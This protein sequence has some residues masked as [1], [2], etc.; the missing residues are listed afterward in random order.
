MQL[1]IPSK[2]WAHG[3]PRGAHGRLFR[4]WGS[5]GISTTASSRLPAQRILLFPCMWYVWHWTVEYL[6]HEVE[7][8]YT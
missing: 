8:V 5:R 4:R 2:L 7:W 6:E 3:G 1:L